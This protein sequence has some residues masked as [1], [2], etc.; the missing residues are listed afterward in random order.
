MLRD[1]SKDDN[2][3]SVLVE[4]KDSDY[5]RPRM[6]AIFAD[7]RL[8][9]AYRNVRGKN[10]LKKLVRAVLGNVALERCKFAAFFDRDYEHDLAEILIPQAFVTDGY[11][12]ENYYTGVDSVRQSVRSL[13]FSDAAHSDDDDK[14]VEEVCALYVSMQNA[15]HE[16]VRLFN[17]WA[18][19]QRH[20]PRDGA[21]ELDRFDTFKFI[22]FDRLGLTL[23]STYS[24]DDLNGLAPDRRA[25]DLGEIAT[26]RIWFSSRD[27][28]ISFRGKQ[29]IEFTYEFLREMIDRAALGLL[30][31]ERKAK[32]S[33]RLSYVEIVSEL[34]AYACT[35]VNLISFLEVR[36]SFWSS[37]S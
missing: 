8:P 28:A 17:E 12:I 34:S 37:S 23:K 35:P 14:V 6:G 3:V 30:P 33:K 18:W 11:S 13:L 32:C 25:V 16:E 10:N 1:H 19:V 24:L 15:F 7:L 20:M 9:L 4:G 31:F 22:E 27:A 29:E 21:L 36:K 5:F 2:V 26:A